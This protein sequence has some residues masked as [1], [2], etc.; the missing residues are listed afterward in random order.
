MADADSKPN[1][2]PEHDSECE[3]GKE[4]SRG[5]TPDPWQGEDYVY[6]LHHEVSRFSVN[7]SKN[8]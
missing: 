3:S 5:L 4:G 8:E 6:A 2:K 7:I 1:H